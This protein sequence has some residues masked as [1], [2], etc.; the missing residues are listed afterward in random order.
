MAQ[1]SDKL[2]KKS[3]MFIKNTVMVNLIFV[4]AVC[5]IAT[6]LLIAILPF[7]A[8]IEVPLI[9]SLWVFLPLFWV[10]GS[11]AFYVREKNTRYTFSEQSLVVR[12]GTFLG[13]STEAMYRY[14]SM[15]SVESKQSRL[16]NKHNYG[17]ISITVPRLENP[18]LLKGV[19]DPHEQARRIKDAVYTTSSNS[20][21]DA[22][23]V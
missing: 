2:V 8:A 18:V 23:V 12:H 14:D 10:I 22:L 20:R 13:S 1:Q 16:G 3:P 21:T 7:S 9:I 11:A 15:L 19:E 17:T 6:L 5:T 4:V